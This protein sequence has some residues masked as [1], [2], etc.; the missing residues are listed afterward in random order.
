VDPLEV[1]ADLRAPVLLKGDRYRQRL[2]AF[3]VVEAGNGVAAPI[4]APAEWMHI[5]ACARQKNRG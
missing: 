4:P 3:G 5:D 1:G 2:T